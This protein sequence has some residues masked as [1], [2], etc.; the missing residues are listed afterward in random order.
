[1]YDEHIKSRLSKDLR[2]FRENKEKLEQKYPYERANKFNKGIRNLGLN[3]EGQSYLDQFR[4]LITHIGK[5]LTHG[6][7]KMWVS[8]SVY[9]T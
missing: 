2:Y 9:S 4:I 1:M 6:V 5:D 7:N 8:T 3:S